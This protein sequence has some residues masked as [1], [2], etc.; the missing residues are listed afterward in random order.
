MIGVDIGGSHIT[1]IEILDLFQGRINPNI[2]RA[3]TALE[4][5]KEALLDHWADVILSLI[6]I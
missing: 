3:H 2:H 4:L 1:S 6:H 5:N